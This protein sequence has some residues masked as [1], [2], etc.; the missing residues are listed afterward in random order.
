VCSHSLAVECV[1]RFRREEFADVFRDELGGDWI[2][3]Q[4]YSFSV[5]L[6]DRSGIF[7]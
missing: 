6:K 1:L 3:A 7:D 4:F 5:L 2:S